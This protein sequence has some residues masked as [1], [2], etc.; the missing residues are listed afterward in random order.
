MFDTMHRGLGEADLLAAIE[1]AAREEAQAGARRLA[2][3]A[4]LVDLTVDEDDE[5][6][7]WAFDPWK[8][9]ACHIGAALSISE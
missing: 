4:E 9:A 8:N 2:A 1:Q 6:G 3:I 5:R 7:M